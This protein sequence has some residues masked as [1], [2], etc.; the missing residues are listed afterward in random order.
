MQHSSIVPEK[1]MSQSVPLTVEK[2]V[3]SKTV[4]PRSANILLHIV[5]SIPSLLSF[6]C[7]PLL[8]SASSAPPFSSDHHHDEE[9][10]GVLSSLANLT[11]PECQEPFEAFRFWL[12]AHPDILRNSDAEEASAE[13]GRDDLSSSRKRTFDDG[14]PTDRRFATCLV[15]EGLALKSLCER[16]HFA[17][18]TELWVCGPDTHV[19]Y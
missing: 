8:A 18:F 4:I 15:R 13:A 7:P 3:M 19:M 11:I 6:L 2:S 14:L 1:I 9:V 5:A 17:M 16:V 10:V 12:R